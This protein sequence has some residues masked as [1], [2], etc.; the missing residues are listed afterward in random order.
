MLGKNRNVIILIHTDKE[1]KGSILIQTLFLWDK[2][3]ERGKNK[4]FHTILL[5]KNQF[6]LFCTLHSMK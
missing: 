1:K 2:G 6:D 3:S 4:I 5:I